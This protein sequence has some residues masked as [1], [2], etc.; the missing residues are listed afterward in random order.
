MPSCEVCGEK[1]ADSCESALGARSYARCK[2]CREEGAES[3]AAICLR[4]FL[5]GGPANAEKNDPGDWWPYGVKSYDDGRYIGWP[6]ILAV[7]P[8]YEMHFRRH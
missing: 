3:I 1:P 8:R 7:Y 5:E 6:E 4:I 2:K